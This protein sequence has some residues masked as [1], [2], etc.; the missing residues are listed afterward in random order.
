MSYNKGIIWTS[1]KRLD[2][3]R[4]TIYLTVHIVGH[5]LLERIFWYRVIRALGT[6]S[7]TSTMNPRPKVSLFGTGTMNPRLE[8]WCLR[9]SLV[10]GE[11]SSLGIY[12]NITSHVKYAHVLLPGFEP[13]TSF[14]TRTSL[15]ISPIYN[16]CDEKRNIF[17]LK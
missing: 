1:N 11:G 17:L 15:T 6:S 3:N 2:T 8:V 14:S 16:T 10:L 9:F 12:L 7:R 13:A 4:S 5:A